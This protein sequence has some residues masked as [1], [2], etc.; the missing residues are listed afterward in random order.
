MTHSMI[1][2][3]KKSE[4][5][6][7]EQ[8]APNPV[9]APDVPNAPAVC[10]ARD[11]AAKSAENNLYIL[12][13]AEAAGPLANAVRTPDYF[14]IKDGEEFAGTHLLVDLWGVKI[15]GDADFARETLINA[16][17]AAGATV[18]HSHIHDFGNGGCSGVVVLAES[19]LSIHTW[20]ERNFIAIDA[21]MC[22]LCDAHKILPV[23]Q[24]AFQPESMHVDTH[25]RGRTG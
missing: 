17:R 5:T 10:E 7:A 24:D 2:A 25:R 1:D 8:N 20:P 4:G 18:L 6:R 22:G 11:G 19:H 23:L 21:F 15:L 9:D 16:A 12:D 14:V 3:V 13:G